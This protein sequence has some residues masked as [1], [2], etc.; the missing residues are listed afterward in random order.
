MTLI[1]LGHLRRVAVLRRRDDHARDLGAVGGRGPRGRRARRSSSFVVEITLV[2][3]TVLFPIQRFGTGA[4]GRL[5]GP[6]MVRVVHDPRGRRRRLGR[7]PPRHPARRLADLRRELPRRARR[8]R[9]RGARLGRPGGDRRRGAVRRHGALRA[10][11]DPPRV[12]RHRVPGADPQLHGPGRADP[13]R[14]RRPSTTR[15]SCCSRT[16]RSCRWS[17]SRRSRPSSR[18]RRSSRARSRSPARRSSSGSCRA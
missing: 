8:R 9:V 12:V 10:A 16:G 13:A 5:F 6:V 17:S 3:I 15:S 11:A 18:R 14:A 1:A 2:I 4:V 7:A